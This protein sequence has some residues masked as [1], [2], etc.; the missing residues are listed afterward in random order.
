MK[1][2][3]IAF[4][5]IAKIDRPKVHA[6]MPNPIGETALKKAIEQCDNQMLKCWIV[7]EAYAGL[8]CQEVAYLE[9]DDIQYDEGR[10]HVRFG[11]GGPG[12]IR[13]A[14]R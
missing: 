3:L 5:P 12:E 14:T 10:I 13:A 4:D 1:K 2:D 11:K 9:H 6:G 7:I 8:R